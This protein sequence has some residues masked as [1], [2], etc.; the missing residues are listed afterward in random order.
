MDYYSFSKFPKSG[1]SLLKNKTIKLKYKQN[2]NTNFWKELLATLSKLVELLIIPLSQPSNPILILCLSSTLCNGLSH[3][4]LWDIDFKTSFPQLPP[5][6]K[7]KKT[8]IIYLLFNKSFRRYFLTPPTAPLPHHRHASNNNTYIPTTPKLQ[9]YQTP[10]HLHSATFLV[11]MPSRA[12]TP[13]RQ[14]KRKHVSLKN[15]KLLSLHTQ[16]PKARNLL[17]PYLNLQS[18]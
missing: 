17:Q 8:Y 11:S 9:C 12:K 1:Y 10:T 4:F 6:S 15:P 14:Q 13:N 5:S 16:N 18:I 2:S 7:T 3:I